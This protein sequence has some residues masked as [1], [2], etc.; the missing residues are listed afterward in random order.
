LTD[1]S[2]CILIY[3]DECQLLC[4]LLLNLNF[5]VP[6]PSD[7]S[8]QLLDEVLYD[9]MSARAPVEIP[10]YYYGEIPMFFI[11][12]GFATFLLSLQLADTL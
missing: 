3:K 5:L 2:I 7:P 4:L 11:S 1:A 6:N 12:T 9:T 8:P 10:G